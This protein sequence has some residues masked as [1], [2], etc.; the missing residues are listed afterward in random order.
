MTRIVAIGECMVEMSPTETAGQFRMGFAGDTMNTAWYLRRL[1]SSDEV[2]DYVSAVGTDAVS[3]NMTDF[4]ERAGIGTTHVLR[5]AQR[6][7]GLYLI[8]LHDGER[9][10][11]YWR[12]ESAARTLARDGSD[13][14]RALAG[15]DIAYFSGITLAIL[16]PV[17]RKNL[18]DALRHFRMAGG[19]VAFDP[20]L[21]PRLW[22]D[23]SEMTAAITEAALVSDIVLPSYEDEATWFGDVDPA[24]TARRYAQG[25][26][27]LVIV[28]NGPGQILA[29]DAGTISR[30]DSVAVQ[31]I[32]DTTAAGDCFNAGI[33]AGRLR[34]LSMEQAIRSAA[35]LAA[36]VVQARG[37]LVSVDP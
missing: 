10:F 32:V 34:G 31:D 28:K 4:L 16:P 6:T 25:G 14:S 33:L 12:G 3:D 18:L 2:I 36:Q 9:S 22:G 21:R 19:E 15:A 5:R 7:V 13:L 17:G 29:W 37:A 1:L 8:Q 35:G 27:G 30:H 24:A 26:A 11:S 20:N 23:P